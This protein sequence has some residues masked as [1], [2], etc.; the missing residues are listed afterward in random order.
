MSYV[1]DSILKT[2]NSGSY[3]RYKNYHLNNILGFTKVSRWELMHSNFI[4]WLLD[5]NNGLAANYEQLYKF[6]LMLYVLKERSLD[7]KSRVNTNVLKKFLN[8]NF[9]ESSMV[10]REFHNIDIL[11][12][13]KTKEKILPIIIENKV[14]SKE[15]GKNKD[16]TTNYF[17]FAEGFYSDTNTYF[18]PIY[19]FL[20]PLYNKTDPKCDKYLKVTYQ[21]LVDY[22][23]EPV[24]RICKDETSKNNIRIYLQSLSFQNDNEKGDQIMAMS[25]EE[26]EILQ[27]F[28]KENGD[29]FDNVIEL[30]DWDE[31]E[32]RSFRTSLNDAADRTKYSFNG[33]NELGKGKLVLNVIKYYCQQNKKITFQQLKGDFPNDLAQNKKQ[34]VV[35]LKSKVTNQAAEKRYFFNDPIT[36]ANGDIVVVSNQWVISKMQGFINHCVKLRL[37]TITVSK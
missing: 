15:N 33:D 25:S 20:V 12:E 9:I 16:Q 37:P 22:V 14:D 18:Q 10:K 35:E 7:N 11:V 1:I 5:N 27:D 36:L 32:K 6:V 4:A 19:I 2:K 3:T 31:K 29:I 26:K 34:G 21:N 23:V 17:D 28:I 8:S 13:I 30:L 24:M